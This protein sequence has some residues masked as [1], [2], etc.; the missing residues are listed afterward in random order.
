[1]YLKPVSAPLVVEGETIGFTLP[2]HPRN[3]GKSWRRPPWKALATVSVLAP[4][5]Q[6]RRVVK[7]IEDFV[8]WPRATKLTFATPVVSAIYR[9]NVIF[10]RRDGT[11]VGRYGQYFRAAPPKFAARIALSN[12]Q[13]APGQVVSA[14]LEN[15]GV[16][17]FGAGYGYR[18]ERFNGTSWEV[19][20][21]LQGERKVPK[22]L[23][24]LGPAATFDCLHLE[25][26]GN[27][28]PGQYRLVKE[29]SQSSRRVIVTRTF[30]VDLGG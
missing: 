3:G 5:G 15:A 28:N 26:P 4:S 30:T 14:R 24:V 6:V 8:R 11:R 29:V 7:R 12:N 18:V 25:I 16:E 23:V 13:F 1:V 17:R 22:V 20:P 27:Q 2:V 9:I 21:S 10:E 19:D